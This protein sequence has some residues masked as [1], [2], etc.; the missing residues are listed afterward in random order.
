MQKTR[1]E[2][3]LPCEREEKEEVFP[4]SVDSA[5]LR[6]QLCIGSVMKTRFFTSIIDSRRG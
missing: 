5:Y 1:S 3:K 2:K 4:L 6:E